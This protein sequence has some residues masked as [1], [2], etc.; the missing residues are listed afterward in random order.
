MYPLYVIT[1]EILRKYTYT[2]KP[3]HGVAVEN[4]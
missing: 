3:W 2:R 1:R 4:D